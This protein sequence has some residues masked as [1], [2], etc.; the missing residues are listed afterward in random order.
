MK[1]R[2]LVLLIVLA[3]VF[4]SSVSLVSAQPGTEL[5][6]VTLG[7]TSVY[8]EASAEAEVVDT[9]GA[10]IVVTISDVVGDFYAID[11]GFVMASDVALLNLPILAPKVVVSTNNAGAT[12]LYAEPQISS[13]FI[14]SAPDGTVATLLTV[15]GEWAF[16]MLMDGAM[17][18]SIVSDWEV[19]SDD[20][21]MAQADVGSSDQVGVYAEAALTSDLVTTLSAGDAV[22]V[23]GPVEER[24]APV[25]LMSGETGYMLEGTYVG[26]PKERVDVV[27]GGDQVPALFAEADFASDLL[28]TLDDGASLTYLGMSEDGYWVEVF[29]PRL[30]MGYVAADVVSSV[31]SWGT[32]QFNSAVVRDGPGVQ[33]YAVAQLAAGDRV[34]V[35]GVTATGEWFEVAIP[36]DQYLDFNGQGAWMNNLLL[37]DENFE[38][39]FNVDV[40][41]IVE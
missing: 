28:G 2:V 26:L 11:G 19:L 14:G 29:D 20:A 30:G 12:G 34:V 31:Y 33:Y 9:L 10:S 24:F 6:A 5:R 15:D 18:W 25:A 37:E 41:P 27:A 35:K 39:D 3:L 38:Y 40:L 22:F 21:M 32:V 4:V 8:G 1:N 7:E 13:E 17:G 16:A 36:L 23:L